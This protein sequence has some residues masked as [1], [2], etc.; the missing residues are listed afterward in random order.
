MDIIITIGA[1]ITAIGTIIGAVNK[2]LDKKLDKVYDVI[3]KHE[4]TI[5][6]R[7]RKKNKISNCFLLS[8][9]TSW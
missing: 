7:D 3:N 6:D 1:Y 9:F 2:L 4:E 5:D 8:I